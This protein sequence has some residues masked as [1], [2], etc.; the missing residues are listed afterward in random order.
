[1]QGG[2]SSYCS[3]FPVAVAVAAAAMQRLLLT[4]LLLVI[5]HV[6]L[7]DIV[8]G[9]DPRSRHQQ[10]SARQL[11]GHVHVT[12]GREESTEAIA[13]RSMAAPSGAGGR[14]AGRAAQSWKEVPPPAARRAG[15]WRVG[16][17]GE[18]RE[19]EGQGSPL[20]GTTL[21]G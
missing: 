1:M 17:G 4:L 10:R 13:G 8:G 7:V 21:A 15:H 12:C 14:C 19:G 18:G 3:C 16:S 5:W 11:A 2:S 6:Q 20:L 9:P